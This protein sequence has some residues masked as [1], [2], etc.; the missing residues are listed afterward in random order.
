MLFSRQIKG[1]IATGILLASIPFFHFAHQ[2]S[3][4]FQG[5]IFSKSGYGKISVEITNNRQSG[6]YFIDNSVTLKSL[7][8][9]IDLNVHQETDYNLEDG[10]SVTIK[11]QSHQSTTAIQ[12]M[13]TEKKVALGL[14][15]DINRTSLDD[16]ILIPGVGEST[17]QKIINRRREIG[18]FRKLEQLTEIS[19][20]KEKKLIK[21]S[22]YL[23]IK[24]EK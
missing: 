24:K 2:Q 8:R 16:L 14:P 7:L 22:K 18:K 20:I 1:I 19:G 21:L 4:D 23:Y 9:E 5:P 3:Y 11:N 10:M 13:C 17:A 12:D 15:L 6:I